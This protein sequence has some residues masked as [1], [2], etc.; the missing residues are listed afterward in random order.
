MLLEEKFNTVLFTVG[1]EAALDALK[2]DNIVIKTID[3]KIQVDQQSITT[4]SNVFA[5]GDCL[6]EK[7]ELASAADQ[8]GKKF[9]KYVLGW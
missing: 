4:T 6:H 1:R 7:P 2:L 9:K 3:N 8:A 5:L